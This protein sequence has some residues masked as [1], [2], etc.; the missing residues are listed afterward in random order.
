MGIYLIVFVLI[1]IFNCDFKGF[2]EIV[3]NK[4]VIK[5]IRKLFLKEENKLIK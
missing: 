1:D 4:C 2:F 3:K 5:K